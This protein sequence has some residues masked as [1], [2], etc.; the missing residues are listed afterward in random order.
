M[1][2]DLA[3]Y[4]K[5]VIIPN[6]VDNDALCSIH[7]QLDCFLC[8]SHGEAWSIPSF[9]AMAF[10]STPICSN[11]GGPPQFISEDD[12]TGFC[13]DGVFTTCKCSDAAFPDIFTGREY[14]F[15]PC[16]MQVRKQM[17]KYFEAYNDNPIKYGVEA[18]AAGLA[19][20]EKFSY[21][22]VGQL[23]K[24]ILND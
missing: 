15:T 13:A 3:R 5:D 22:A 20:A 18:K 9:D 4:R 8:P 24:E 17:R 10:G 6:E 1:Y 23:M 7:Q 16:E 19:Q 2:G 12:R 11:F 21:E 14:W